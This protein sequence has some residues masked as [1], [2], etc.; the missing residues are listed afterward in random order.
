MPTA[1]PNLL[2]PGGD[3]ACAGLADSNPNDTVIIATVDSP[4]S[5]DIHENAASDEC[6]SASEQSSVYSDAQPVEMALWAYLWCCTPFTCAVV[7]GVC[8]A[9][10]G[11]LDVLELGAGLAAPSLVAAQFQAHTVIASDCDVRAKPAVHAASAAAP[12]S[13]S[14]QF[15]M[16]DW[17]K[18]S[19]RARFKHSGHLVIAS[20]VLYQHD[21]VQPLVDTIK[22]VLHPQGLAVIVDP[23]RPARAVFEAVCQ[24]DPTLVFECLTLHNVRYPNSATH[25]ATLHVML[26]RHR[27]NIAGAT[28]A[29]DTSL[30]ADLATSVRELVSRMRAWCTEQPGWSVS[31]MAHATWQ[32]TE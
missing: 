25:L 6:N 23:G 5:F 8:S 14:T 3:L 18:P 13:C 16:L 29:E 27:Q 31:D 19:D 11:Q 28:R 1:I 15:H 21:L 4:D 30:A 20:D 9:R 7:R 17:N 26:L 22:I 2:H 32:P 24:A 10:A 12:T